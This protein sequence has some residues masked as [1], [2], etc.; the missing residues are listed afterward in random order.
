M[1]FHK[2]RRFLHDI[3]TL[4]RIIGDEFLS[5]L[6]EFQSKFWRSQQPIPE[7][8]TANSGGVNGQFWRSQR[9]ILEEPGAGG[10]LGVGGWG[11]K[12]PNGMGPLIF[13]LYI[14]TPELLSR[15]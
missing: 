4:K 12:P 5:N 10:R 14:R 13:Y 9:L 2:E 6:G 15:T 11:A 1:Y 7:E 8:S 3:C